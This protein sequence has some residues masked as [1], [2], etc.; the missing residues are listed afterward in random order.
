[1]IQPTD[2]VI[3]ACHLDNPSLAR[4][5]ASPLLQYT[6]AHT[7]A[8]ARSIWHTCANLVDVVV[9]EAVPSEPGTGVSRARCMIVQHGSL[10]VLADDGVKVVS[11]GVFLQLGDRNGSGR[12][13]LDARVGDC[14]REPGDDVVCAFSPRYCQ[15]CARQVYSQSTSPGLGPAANGPPLALIACVITPRMTMPADFHN[16]CDCLYAACRAFSCW[17]ALL[18]LTCTGCTESIQGMRDIHQG[19]PCKTRGTPCCPSAWPPKSP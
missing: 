1:M 9:L 6:F 16:S 17:S 12:V 5:P 3:A 11:A 4:T 2:R 8:V 7:R 14:P 15:D 18:A 13:R 10:P 19:C